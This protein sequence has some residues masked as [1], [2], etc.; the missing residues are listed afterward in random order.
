MQR[1]G[2]HH[3][4]ARDFLELFVGALH[5]IAAHHGLDGLG[6]HFPARVQVHRQ[7][8]LVQFQLVQASQ[9]RGIGQRGITQGHAHVAQH[10]AVGQVAL[11]AADGQLFR[12]VA[13][14]CVGQAQV[15]FGVFKVDRV[16]LVRHGAG[17]NLAG[18]QA[19]LEV[20]QAH[21]APDVAREVYQNGVGAR[22]GIKQLGHVVVRLDLDAVGLEREAQAQGL[23]RFDDLLAEGFPVKVGPGREVGVVVAH[24]A[25]HL[26]QDLDGG[27]ALAGGLQAHEH[28]G[29]FLAHGGGAGG[30]AVR[31]AEHGHVGK[32]VGHFAQFEDDAVQ[33]RQH[34]LVAARAQL[35]GVAGVVDVFAGAGKVHE[36]RCFFELGARFKLGLDPVFDG[37]HVVVGGFFDLL[38]GSRIGLGEVLDQAQQIGAGASGQRLEF[39]KAGIRQRDEP[40]HL[41]L[42]TALH[43]AV[44]AHD[45]PQ[46]GKFGGV[47]A[48]K[49]RQG[50]DGGQAHGARL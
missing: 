42:H 10:G 26:A 16:D 15:A 41:H 7:S 32:G 46:C 12:E 38:D 21:I 34:H 23:G 20:A 35:Q 47:T 14:Q 49:R 33:P 19:L 50:S 31:A 48:V 2:R 13:Q 45:G 43:V 30:L 8:F 1:L 9:Q 40:G 6:Q 24:G 44:L 4:A 3:L 25:V 36:F 5:A 22:H 18:L 28:V 27:N 29:H 39:G 17:A 37:F 11:P